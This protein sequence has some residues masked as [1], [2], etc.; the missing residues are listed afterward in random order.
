MPTPRDV[1]SS[2]SMTLRPVYEASPPPGCRIR[3]FV[4][5]ELIGL[6]GVAC[7]FVKINSTRF[8]EP[9]GRVIL[10]DV[11]HVVASKITSLRNTPFSPGSEPVES[12]ALPVKLNE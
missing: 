5:P 10:P 9:A 3:R 2:G 12:V 4:K 8:G 7:V 6:V 1:N 11:V